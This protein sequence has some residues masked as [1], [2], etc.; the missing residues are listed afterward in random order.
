MEASSNINTPPP[1]Y[2]SLRSQLH[3]LLRATPYKTMDRTAQWIDHASTMTANPQLASY[4]TI[5]HL[6]DVDGH[7]VRD[8]T[9]EGS[10][11]SGPSNGS[12]FSPMDEDGDLEAGSLEAGPDDLDDP[13]PYTFQVG[14]FHPS[15]R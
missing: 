5:G 9:P 7:P 4:S 11:S 6:Y 13:W 12:D 14:R 15:R 10:E 2:R 8:L 1:N 3:S